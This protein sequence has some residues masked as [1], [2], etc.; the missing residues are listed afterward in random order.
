MITVVRFVQDPVPA[1]TQLSLGL[2]TACGSGSS[3]ADASSASASQKA[4][5]GAHASDNG[6]QGHANLSSAAGGGKLNLQEGDA[7]G[8][9]TFQLSVNGGTEALGEV[10]APNVDQ[11]TEQFPSGKRVP[12]G[13][14]SGTVTVIRGAERS[15]QLTD[16]IEGR[17]QPARASLSQLDA[18]GNPTKQ[19][20]PQE[21]RAIKV[22]PRAATPRASRSSSRT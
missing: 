10:S 22:P 16:L 5:S 8:A 1:A 14:K 18:T 19:Y 2:L 9:H 13:Q 3:G 17:T 12:G 20:A 7:L 4:E 21:P 15:R 11:P 6:A